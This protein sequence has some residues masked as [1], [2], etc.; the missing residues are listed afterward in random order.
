MQTNLGCAATADEAESLHPLPR[1]LIAIQP[2]KSSAQERTHA[3]TRRR[4][5]AHNIQTSVANGNGDFISNI[6]RS[7]LI[8]FLFSSRSHLVLFMFF[9]RFLYVFFLFFSRSHLVL[10]LFSSRSLFVLFL[11]SSRSHLVPFM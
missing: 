8:L 6:C 5:D 9:S 10:F 2:R 3:P 1:I 7:L 4:T 11:F